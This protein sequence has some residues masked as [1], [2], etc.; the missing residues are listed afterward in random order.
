MKLIHPA[1]L[2][3]FLSLFMWGCNDS[4]SKSSSD[5]RA[6]R[7]FPVRAIVLEPSPFSREFNA[8]GTFEPNEQVNLATEIPGRIE[9]IHFVEGEIVKKGQ[10]LVSINAEDIMAERRRLETALENAVS[11]ANRGKQLREL[12]AISKEELEDLEFEVNSLQNQLAENKVRLNRTKIKAPF[13][14]ITGFRKLSP[15]AYVNTGDEIV[16]IVQ[17]HPLKVQ[18][19]LPQKYADQI[20]EGDSITIDYGE[21]IRRKVPVTAISY[22]IQEANRSFSIRTLVDNKDREILPGSFANIHVPIYQTDSALLVPSEAIIKTIEEEEIFVVKNGLAEKVKVHTGI[23]NEIAVEILQGCSPGDTVIITG[24]VSLSE[25]NHVSVSLS[26][27]K[28][29]RQ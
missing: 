15:G 9:S 10:L 27:W 7:T 26:D 28:N 1:I 5:K 21:A 12:Q 4:P 13:S 22:R 11:K 23:R 16:E 8:T 18:F 6:G 20:K 3:V 19:E 24:L 2:L 14:G 17:Y 25:G 29:T